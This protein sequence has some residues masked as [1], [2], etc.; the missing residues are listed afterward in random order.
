MKR[1]LYSLI[2][3]MPMVVQAM[4]GYPVPVQDRLPVGN[5][6]CEQSIKVSNRQGAVY[7]SFDLPNRECGPFAGGDVW[8]VADAP[9]SGKLVVAGDYSDFSLTRMAFYAFRQGEL[10]WLA[11]AFPDRLHQVPETFLQNLT[12]GEPILVRI[13]DAGNDEIGEARICAFD[14]VRRGRVG[15]EPQTV[16]ATARLQQAS[17]LVYPNPVSDQLIIDLPIEN[18]PFQIFLVDITGRKVLE[19]AIDP[20]QSRL[21]WDVSMQQP[22]IYTLFLQSQEGVLSQ[23]IQVSP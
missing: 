19:S 10:V 18:N 11:C 21:I 9:V 7:G 12:P 17:A 2:L 1:L 23:R 16:D 13:W 8:V 14:P 4:G 6:A 15:R 3:L 22:G 5:G 20:E